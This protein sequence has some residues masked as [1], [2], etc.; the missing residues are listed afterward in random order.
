MQPSRRLAAVLSAVPAA[1]LWPAPSARGED[2]EPSPPAFAFVD[3]APASGFRDVAGKTVAF[4]DVNHDGW[5]DVVLDRRRVFLSDRGTH[6]A[7]ADVGLPFP[8]VRIVPLAADGSADTAKAAEREYVPQ[9][10]HFADLDGDGDLDALWM[11]HSDWERFD[12]ATTTFVAVPE[13]DPG[14]RTSVFVNDGKGRF[15]RG[16]ESGITAKDAYGPS[17]AV[18]VVDFD[19]DGVADVFEGREYRRYGV[20][21]GCGGDRLWRGDGKGGFSDVT[22][23]AGMRLVPEPGLPNSARPNYGVTAADFDGDGWTD[24]VTMAY[25]R[26]WNLQWRNRSDGTFV[27]IG[28]DTGFAGDA[29]THGRYPERVNRPAEQPF[30]SNGNTF[31]CAVADFDADG[32]LDAFL[33]EIQHAW[34]GESSD[35]PSLLVNLGREHGHRFE[36]RPVASFLPKRPFRDERNFNYGDLH[37]A[38]LDHDLDGR[39]DLLIASGDYPDGQFLRLYR[40]RDDGAFDEVTSSLP[41]WEG[42]GG[43]SVGDFDRDGD[44]DILVGRSFMR[45]SEEHRKQHMGGIS[46][47]APGLLRNDAGNRSGNRWLHVTLVGRGAGGANRAALGARVHVTAGGRTQMREIRSG[48]G[49]GNH[50]DPTEQIFG[51]GRAERIEKVVV[52]W[53][54]AKGTEQTFTGVPTD[55]FVTFVEGEASPRVA[56]R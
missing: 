54:D 44:P 36:R 9:V 28:R 53:P 21:F 15:T 13:C 37:A 2:P 24:L 8:K 14:V 5:L 29:I 32:D 39:L 17:S 55:R 1:V 34:A 48:S 22:A 18:T 16:P 30:R 41:V 46:V 31:D 6:F 7:E 45:L 10:L 56:P 12:E 3:T 26:Q 19:R 38:W 27:E 47:P 52:R 4:A 25:G 20:L 35:P 40:Q 33:G 43:V 11:V 50:Q 42:C 23:A 51:L 49:L